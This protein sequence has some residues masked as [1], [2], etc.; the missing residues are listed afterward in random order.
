MFLSMVLFVIVCMQAATGKNILFAAL[1]IEGYQLQVL[2][3]AV[4]I[5]DEKLRRV[6]KV[7]LVDIRKVS[8]KHSLSS[9]NGPYKLHIE[10]NN[11]RKHHF[12]FE[13]QNIPPTLKRLIQYQ[14][15]RVGVCIRPLSAIFF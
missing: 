3:D 11:D 13:S 5:V 9:P 1:T 8:R 2:P 6:L 15:N 7:L 12:T 14:C 4:E 10:T